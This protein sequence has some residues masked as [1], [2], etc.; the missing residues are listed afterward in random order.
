[1]GMMY[2]EDL[3]VGDSWTS[4]E[5]IACDCGEDDGVALHRDDAMCHQPTSSD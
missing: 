3:I 1:M 2:F 5:Y 4:T